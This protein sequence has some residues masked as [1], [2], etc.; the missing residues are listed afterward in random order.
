M[1]ITVYN[2]AGDSVDQV[3]VDEAVLGG[4]PNFELV[5]QAVVTYEANQRVGTARAQRIDQVTRTSA[6]P[7]RQ[8]HTGRARQGDRRSPIWVGG[9]VAHG[10]LPRDYRKKLSRSM[11]RRALQSAFLAKAADDEVM[12]VDKIELEQKKT[13]EVAAM[14]KALGV[15]RSFAIVLDEYD[16][17]L[18][19]CTRNIP[20]AAMT[21]ASDLNAYSMIRPR[22]VIF[23]RAGL[24]AFLE[25]NARQK[26]EVNNG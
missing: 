20:G 25:K 16:A 9:G 3:T 18:W 12:V 8:K 15:E 11:R 14:L 10:P 5:R 17:E 1:D 19:R 24:D 22:Q 21:R 4:E 2:M 26:A 13:R 7:W 6:K 23:T